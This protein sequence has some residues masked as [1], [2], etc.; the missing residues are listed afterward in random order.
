M[1]NQLSADLLRGLFDT[2]PPGERDCFLSTLPGATATRPPPKLLTVE[3][4]AARFEC[5]PRT[6]RNW[7]ST[8]EVPAIKRGRLIRVPEDALYKHAPRGG[9][10]GE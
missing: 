10:A 7:I 3:E 9:K 4:V 8:G 5:T 6:V 2:L 1:S